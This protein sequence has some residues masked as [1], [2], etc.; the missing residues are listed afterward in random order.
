M[1]ALGA[2]V[3]RRLLQRATI[4]HDHFELRFSERYYSLLRHRV[5]YFA[6]LAEFDPLF[7]PLGVWIDSCDLH[8][9]RNK[10][11]CSGIRSPVR[12]CGV[13]GMC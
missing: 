11:A 8:I 7:V 13:V 6:P 9:L 5:T 4:F 10:V 3:D 12:P 2:E 1:V